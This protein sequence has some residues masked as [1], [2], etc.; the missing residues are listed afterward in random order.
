MVQENEVIMLLL[1]IGVLIFV[2][3]NRSV[4]QRI[5]G[6]RILIAGFF[7]QLAGWFLT[8]L[9]GFV[10]ENLFN[11]F[12]HTCY[13]VSSLLLAFWCLKARRGKEEAG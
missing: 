13:A 11:Y 10:L 8:V 6:S 3:R 7:I 2:L 12:E 1:G 9:E 5:P 4:I